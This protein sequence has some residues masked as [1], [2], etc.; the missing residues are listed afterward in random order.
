MLS[1]IR[2]LLELLVRFY[3]ADQE[4]HPDECLEL[5]RLRDQINLNLE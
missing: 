1:L 3:E 2:I 4:L 5:E